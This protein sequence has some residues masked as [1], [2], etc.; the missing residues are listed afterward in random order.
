MSGFHAVS[1]DEICHRGSIKDGDVARL[2]RLIFTDTG[3]SEAEAKLLFRINDACKV[4]D[5]SWPEFFIEALTDYVVNEAEP[6]G[7]ITT[8][9][10]A[11][12]MAEISRD[13]RVDSK[14]ELELLVNLLGRARWSPESLV[15]FTLDQVKHAV[16]SGT[17]PLRAGAEP[18]PGV[19]HE[20][21]VELLR[22]ILYAF[23][24]DGNMSITRAEAEVL[25]EINDATAGAPPNPDWT[26]LFVKA[27]ANCV[28]GASG[29]TVPSRE[30]ALRREG[31]LES[32]GDLSIARIVAGMATGWLRTAYKEQ[33]PEERALAR[34]ECQRIEIITN[35]EVTQGEVEWLAD[36]LG[37]DGRLTENERAALDFLLRESPKIHP[38]LAATVERLGKAA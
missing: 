36:R 24:G 22:R 8:E 23:G 19:I 11:W 4:Q 34:L 15:R 9:L 25:F 18:A 26:D 3:M 32:R 27:V 38:A 10:A 17:G 2:R 7:Y 13:G 21:E 37:R 35:E 20:G 29:Y 14:T 1:I 16:I 12:L 6:R 30:E 33:T 28:M 31:W 5:P